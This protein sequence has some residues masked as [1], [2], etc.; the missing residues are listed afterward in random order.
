MAITTQVVTV[1]TAVTTIALPTIDA[2]NLWI[3]NL[4]PDNNIGSFSRNGYAYAVNQYFTLANNGVARFS[5]TTGETGAQF[6]YWQ[7]DADGSSILAE[8][9]EGATI[10][11]TATAVPAHNLNRDF[12]DDYEAELVTA[13]AITGGTVIMAEFIPSSNQS[14]GGAISN[15][16]V[17]LKPNT[18]YGFRFTDVGGNGPKA[19]VQIIWIE[20]YNGYNDVWLNGSAGSAVR[21]RGGE[22]VQLQLQ[23]VEGITGVATREGVRVA[24]MRQD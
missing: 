17:T 2:Q 1:G 13:S 8:L 14:G 4:E 5:F 19:F 20:K 11:T 18:Q 21:L 9:L 12:A 6:D 16:I 7:F 3:E 24:V 10:T 23:Q 22:K 15:K